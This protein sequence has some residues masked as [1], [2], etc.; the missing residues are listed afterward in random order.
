MLL[1]LDHTLLC[2]QDSPSIIYHGTHVYQVAMVVKTWLD[3]FLLAVAL[4][5]KL[6]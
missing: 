3:P 2:G 5:S 4:L 6:G 1:Y